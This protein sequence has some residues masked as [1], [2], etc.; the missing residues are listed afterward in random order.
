M[1]KDLFIIEAPPAE[2]VNG[3]KRPRGVESFLSVQCKSSSS[4]VKQRID[5]AIAKRKTERQA[6]WQSVKVLQAVNQTLDP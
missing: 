4:T 2:V 3:R 1:Q 6:T 5:C